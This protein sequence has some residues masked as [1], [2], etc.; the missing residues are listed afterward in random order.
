MRYW[1]NTVPRSH[2]LLG[3][4]GGFTQADHGRETRLRQL[5]RDDWLVF[6]AP[7]TELRGG[8]PLQAFTAIG[9]ISDDVPYQVEMPP[10]FHPW[11]RALRV[12]PSHEAPIP[13]LIPTLDFIADTQRWDFPFRRGLFA[14]GQDDFARIAAAMDV[15][16]PPALP[17]P[18]GP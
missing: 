4:A 15:A 18:V 13:P 16:L 12:A 5:Q 1:I 11:R 6:Y 10:R 3:V 14:I 7:R 17:L 9:Q 2:V 8:E